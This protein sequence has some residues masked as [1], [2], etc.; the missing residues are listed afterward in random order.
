[1][2]ELLALL[3]PI[4]AASGWYA[5][6]KTFRSEYLTRRAKE[7][8]TS[9]TRGFG[10]LLQDKMDEAMEALSPVIESD[11]ESL[12]LRLALGNFFRRRGE[13][14]KALA[15]HQALASQ[16]GLSADQR[17]CVSYEL[18]MD[19]L[20]AGLLDRAEAC[21]SALTGIERYRAASLQQL[22]KI[23]QHEKDWSNAIHCARSLQTVNRLPHHETVA[24][25]YCELA[26]EQ[27][28][29]DNDQRAIQFLQLARNEDDRCVRASIALGKI[30]TDKGLWGE[31]LAIL[32]D[33]ER[34]DPDFLSETLE[35]IGR[36]LANVGLECEFPAHLQRLYWS[37]S[38]EDA[39]CLL[40]DYLRN[41]EGLH[42][43]CA[44]LQAAIAKDSSLKLSRKLM[45]L[46]VLRAEEGEG[47]LFGSILR[48]VAKPAL[49]RPRYRCVQCGFQ[50]SE[51]HW[52][53]PSCQSWGTVKP[54]R[55]GDHISEQ[56]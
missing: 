19:Y 7:L 1:M 52:K 44:Y 48:S 45:Q 4:A 36:C 21:F 5:A 35:P 53:C 46:L 23:Y 25:F 30:L 32:R 26:E 10:L 22:L 14:E 55:D 42:A 49:A 16:G 18:G 3:L 17:A 24:Q 50:G 51:L 29:A 43:A 11:A 38:C 13:V 15:M 37:Y 39:A 12:E 47:G 34:Q 28:A 54:D 33:V 56:F 31:A 27:L 41:A 20:G 2:I 9:C 8:H 6:K 40:A